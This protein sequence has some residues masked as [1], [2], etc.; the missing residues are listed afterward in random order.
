MRLIVAVLLTAIGTFSCLA[1][2]AEPS[3]PKSSAPSN[4]FRVTLRPASCGGCWVAETAN[5]RIQWCTPDKKSLCGLAETCEQLA[6]RSKASWGAS[7]SAPWVPACDIVVHPDSSD[8]VASMGLA[9]N[10]TSGCTTIRTDG[11][12][13]VLRRI[14]LCADALDWWTETLPHELTHVVLA[15][16]FTTGRIS[17]WADEGIAMLSE[18]SAKRNRRLSALR[19]VVGSGMTYTVRDLMDVRTCPEPALRIAF[20][21]QSVAL[22]SLLLEWGTR[23]QLLEFVQASQSQGA[24]A[25]LAAVYHNRPVAELERQLAESLSSDRVV[26]LT[27]A[28]RSASRPEWRSTKSE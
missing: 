1:A 12:R 16:R 22:V 15:D 8:Y 7:D 28:G 6:A 27:R 20:Y 9:S 24:D 21:G 2:A 11:G 17:P 18:T 4:A 19:G 10:Q 26:S 23:Q 5:F 14:D 3:P 25:A 13:V